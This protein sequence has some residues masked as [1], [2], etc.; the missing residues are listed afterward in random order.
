MPSPV[1]LDGDAHAIG[2]GGAQGDRPIGRRMAQG[3]GQQV[4]QHLDQAVIVGA[5]L[6]RRAGTSTAAPRF[7]RR[8][9]SESGGGI[10]QQ[11]GKHEGLG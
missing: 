11:I 3:V 1:S 4:G 5:D 8:P 7:R 6:R 2:D 9:G 10:G